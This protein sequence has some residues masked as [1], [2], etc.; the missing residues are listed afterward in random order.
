MTSIQPERGRGNAA[1]PQVAPIRSRR[2]YDLVTGVG[3]RARAAGLVNGSWYKSALPRPLLKTLIARSDAP[4]L[5]D[6]LIWYALILCAGL[7]AYLS[8]GTAW[9]MPAFFLYGT[10]YAGPADSR[11]HETGHGTA[12]RTRWLNTLL[13]QMA[14]FQVMRRPMVWRWSH[15]RHHAD[16][17]VTG[18]DPEIQARL[19]ISLTHLLADFFGLTLGPS[20]M[21]GMLINAAGRLT[22]AEKSFIPEGD[23]PRVVRQ[24]RAWTAVYAAV[25]GA[26]LA[27]S[28]WLPL[29]F[30]GLPS[31]Y[32]AWLYNFFGLTQHA[33]LPENGLDHRL[34][35]RTVLMNPVFR[36]LYWNMNYHVEHH[37]YPM[38]PYHALPRLHEAIVADCPPPYASNWA[39]YREILPALLRQRRDPGYFVRR[40]L[41]SAPSFAGAT[42]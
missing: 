42:P 34:N 28:S 36:F 8:L 39:A 12:F 3:E 25:I 15:A 21:A 37:M 2:D 10:L 41:P 20:E 30:I 40:P 16:T 9:A 31:V 33:A 29:L 19:P 27:L 5:R 18:R 6:T 24:A 13:Y 22:A 4:A 32:G 35:S 23:W 7:L 26:S 11:W 1:G 14:S 38:V 17:L